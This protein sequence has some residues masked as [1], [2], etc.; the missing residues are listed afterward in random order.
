MRIINSVIK[1][2]S[3]AE[4]GNRTIT[5]QHTYDTG[6][7]FLYP[8]IAQADWDINAILSTRAANIN[9]ELER[10]ELEIAEAN[11]FEIPLTPLDIQRR[12]TPAEWAAFIALTS[13][14]AK[15]FQSIFASGVPIHRND[16]LTQSARALLI[17]NGVL[18]SE[19][20]A[21]VFA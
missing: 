18:T 17:A 1:N 13:D 5:E 20:D 2:E 9:A 12:I 6:N 7:V 4:N 10:R 3:V 19:R 21:V 11:N 15:Y 16:P 14:E 8:Y